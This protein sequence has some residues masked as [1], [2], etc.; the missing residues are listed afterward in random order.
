MPTLETP[1]GNLYYTYH[2]VENSAFP[3]LILVHGAGGD[4]LIWPAELRRFPQASVYALDLPAH[5]RSDGQAQN[6]ILGYAESVY[7]FW[8]ALKLPPAVIIGHSMGGAIAQTIALNFS[9][10]IIGLVLIG[11]GPYLTVNPKILDAAR[12]DLNALASMIT[13]WQWGPAAS[14]QL[15]QLGDQQLRTGNPDV[16]YAD[17]VACSTFDVSTQLS[18]IT[19]PTLVVGGTA[20]KMTPLA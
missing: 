6:T 8:H 13:R 16:V 1:Q 12:N 5:G 3:P 2:V 15:R 19:I 10:M 11:T 7:Q 9:E 18:Q 20:D 17:Y 4:H 14:E